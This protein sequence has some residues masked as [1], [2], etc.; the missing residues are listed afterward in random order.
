MAHGIFKVLLTEKRAELPGRK[1]RKRSG[2]NN[3][4]NIWKINIFNSSTQCLCRRCRI[5]RF[6]E[7]S[8]ANWLCASAWS[9]STA[10]RKGT[11]LSV[12]G[13]VGLEKQLVTATASMALN[14]SLKSQVK[15][16][17]RAKCITALY[18]NFIGKD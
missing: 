8:P 4:G 6:T 15:H 2:K 9:T 5:R 11:E 3:L 14:C 17:H 7:Q 18:I 10:M 1:G 16:C 12:L 13:L